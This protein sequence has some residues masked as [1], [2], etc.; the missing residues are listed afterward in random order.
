MKITNI[1]QSAKVKLTGNYIKCAS[2]S[3][4]Y[5]IIISLLTF[6]QTKSINTI[7]NSAILA[8]VQAFLLI[9]NWVFS[10]G[11]IANILDLVDIKTNSITDFINSTLKRGLKYIRIGLIFLLKILV[12]LIIFL[13]TF[14]YWIGTEVAK[15]NKVNFLC[16]N[17]NLSLLAGLICVLAGISLVYYIL[18]YMLVA[19]IYYENPDMSEKEIVEKSKTLMKGHIHQYILLLL[20]FLHWFLIAALILLILNIFIESKFLTPFMVLFYSII[21]PYVITS[22]FEFY[23][24]LDDVKE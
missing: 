24:E 10:Y 8:I 16:F 4:L 17:Q 11:I 2:S 12:P 18:K 3:L 1:K 21:R 7:Q 23:K 6:F 19:Y 14:F 22:K 15:I 9:I 5:F 13:F 20:S